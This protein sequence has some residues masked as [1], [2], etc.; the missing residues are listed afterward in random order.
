MKKIRN[1]YLMI[2]IGLLISGCGSARIEKPN[3]DKVQLNENA[4]KNIAELST[5][6]AYYHSVAQGKKL[7]KTGLGGIIQKERKFWIE[8]TGNVDIGIDMNLVSISIEDENIKIKIP[9]ARVL[10][11][12]DIE[13]ETFNQDSYVIEDD[14]LFKNNPITV[15]DQREAISKARKDIIEKRH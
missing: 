4:I 13:Q 7:R 8:F 5:H 10:T 6:K 9:K 1:I 2:I 15:E 14:N 12:V 11:D 3:Q